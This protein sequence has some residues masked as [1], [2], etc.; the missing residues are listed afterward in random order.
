MITRYKNLTVTM[1]IIA[2]VMIFGGGC[3]SLDVFEE[4]EKGLLSYEEVRN[5]LEEEGLELEETT[6]DSPVK[7]SVQANYVAYKLNNLETVF[8]YR[9]DSTLSRKQV[10]PNAIIRDDKKDPPYHAFSA[11]NIT[12][13]YPTEYLEKE[14][15]P[16]V[17]RENYDKVRQAVLQSMVVFGEKF[18]FVTAELGEPVK[19]NFKFDM[20]KM[21][22]DVVL[23]DDFSKIA[24]LEVYGVDTD[25]QLL[26]E[27]DSVEYKY[28][29]F[30]NHNERHGGAPN[31]ENRTKP[32]TL[33]HVR[34][35]NIHDDM[36]IRYSIKNHHASSYV[37]N[38]EKA[39]FWGSFG[40]DTPEEAFSR[41]YDPLIMMHA[42]YF[43][44]WINH[45]EKNSGEIIIYNPGQKIRYHVYDI[46][47]NP[48]YPDDMFEPDGN[49]YFG[50]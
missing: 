16:S 22:E 33:N 23:M 49:Y 39:S 15:I 43:L 47:L 38:P 28:A 3:T 10:F 29:A 34:L 27:I 36:F 1:L 6:A 20:E 45:W 24:E 44:K 35:K 7:E 14:V 30:T 50:N 48:D 4:S 31:S 41:L 26:D 25:R 9:F 11:R 46:K 37:A 32:C 17:I 18:E 12:V 40:D 2:A 8:V 42:E 19:G 5:I 21:G 13:I